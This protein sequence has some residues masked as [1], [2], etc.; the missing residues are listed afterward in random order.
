M[1]WASAETLHYKQ[2]ICKISIALKASCYS[3]FPLDSKMPCMLSQA[4]RQTQGHVAPHLHIPP[5][6]SQRLSFEPPHWGSTTKPSSTPCKAWCVK[7][8]FQII[9]SFTRNRHKSPTNCGNVVKRVTTETCS[10]KF[11]LFVSHQIY[12]DWHLKQQLMASFHSIRQRT[13]Y[14]WTWECTLSGA[15]PCPNSANHRSSLSERRASIPQE[16]SQTRGAG[17]TLAAAIATESFLSD[18]NTC[19]RAQRTV[20]YTLLISKIPVDAWQGTDIKVVS[21]SCRCSAA[22]AETVIHA[23]LSI[24]LRTQRLALKQLGP[25]MTKLQSWAYQAVMRLIKAV[26]IMFE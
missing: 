11:A 2:F 14:W 20:Q 5:V 13:C 25:A 15:I 17:F 9:I 7:I 26:G 18:C 19:G 6:Y 3:P 8:C 24:I 4:C 1:Y 23:R 21:S 22:A 10:W 16:T 12:D